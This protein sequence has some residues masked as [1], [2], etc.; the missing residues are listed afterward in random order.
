MDGRGG[1]RRGE[2]RPRERVHI[3][4]TP[5]PQSEK[6]DPRHQMAG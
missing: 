2:K 5:H 6:N 4:H 1:K 3:A